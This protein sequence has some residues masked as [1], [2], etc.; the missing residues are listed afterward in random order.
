[1]SK[2][3]DCCGRGPAT[4]NQIS[5]S[6]RR[7]RRRWQINLQNVRVDLGAGETRKMKICAH[8]LRSGKVK[9]AATVSA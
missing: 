1:M 8:C 4:G 2:V 9:R 7:T 5:H 3:C 6:H